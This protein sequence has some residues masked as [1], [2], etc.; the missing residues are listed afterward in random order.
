LRKAN[1]ILLSAI[2]TVLGPETDVARYFEKAISS[3]DALDLLLAQAAFQDLSGD[4]KMS[5][6]EGVRV[7]T[8]AEIAARKSR[9]RG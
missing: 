6:A 8:E 2:E 9:G 5:I 1:E 3:E 7:A 4:D